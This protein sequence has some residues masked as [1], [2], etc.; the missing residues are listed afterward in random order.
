VV[1]FDGGRNGGW[2]TPVDGGSVAMVNRRVLEG[3][4]SIGKL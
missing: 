1:D 2:E 4:K 3:L